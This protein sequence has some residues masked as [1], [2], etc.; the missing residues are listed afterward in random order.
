MDS[1]TL[2]AYSFDGFRV[3]L[4]RRQLF[5]PDGAPLPLPSRAYDVLIHLIANRDHVVSKDEL[6]TAVWPRSVVEENNVNQAVSAVRRALADQRDSPRFI[7]TVAGRG[8]RFVADVVEDGPES[9]PA[10]SSGIPPTTAG[11]ANGSEPEAGASVTEPVPPAPSISRRVLLAGMTSAVAA[12]AGWYLWTR[13]PASVPAHAPTVAVL[14]F[15]PLV[16]SAS[17]ESLELGMADALINRLSGL[18][19][20]VVAPWSSVRQYRD[21]D[22]DPLAAG[23]ELRVR[24]VLE[25]NIQIQPERVRLTA[26][27]LDVENGAALWSGQ[28]DEELR[29][30][31]VVQDALARQIVEALEVPLTRTALARL[32]RRP[33]S[34]LEAWQ[35]Y[36]KGR[37]HWGTRNENGLRQAIAYYEAALAADPGLAPAAAGLS[38]AWAVLA[39]FSIDPPVQAMDHARRAAQS[40]VA[41]DAELAEAQASLGHVLV[42]GDR[43]WKGGEAQFHKALA[44]NPSY[45][46][47]MFWLANVS[48]MQGDM[49]AALSHARQAQAMEPLS[50]AFAGNVGL[51]QYFARDFDGAR[52]TLTDLVATVPA[53]QLSR[54]FLARVHMALGNLPEAFE[55]LRGHEMEHA[56][57][58]M[59]DVGR[60]LAL[61]GQI[62]AARREVARIKGLGAKGFGVGFDLAI[63]HAAL[64]ER[65]EA[66]H[67]LQRS[68]K[69]GSQLVGFLN[70]EPQFDAIRDD[71]RF[72]AVSRALALG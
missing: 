52:R 42:Q 17:N 1:A 29:D 67:A 26:R 44:L 5:G 68:L 72:R 48:C 15:Q 24:A 14:P 16:E 9:T 41:L 8:Y 30:F 25:S 58:W 64:G 7:A 40:A 45:G 31:F 39:V 46:Q 12:G 33:T 62:D 69:D 55:L 70:S 71:S 57:G 61:D 65:D 28:F 32:N 37:F 21:R 50:A 4:V 49:A 20:V 23:R 19:G 59:S 54:R 43:N 10:A 51:I 56:P 35:L 11:A 38:D 27:L 18:P 60:L 53:Y 3:D 66:I 34:D 22:Q 36:L 47:A 6:M 13:R 63:I 2:R